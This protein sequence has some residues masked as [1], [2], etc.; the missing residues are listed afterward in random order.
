MLHLQRETDNPKVINAVAVIKDEA[1]VVGHIP[2]NLSYLVYHFLARD[3]NQAVVEITGRC[4]N[5]GAGYGLEVPCVS[6]FTDRKS[7]L[8]DSLM[9]LRSSKFKV[10]CEELNRIVLSLF[11]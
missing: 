9:V 4:V 2:Y 1:T 3:V 5:R 10:L 8:Q 7:S 6:V 11:I